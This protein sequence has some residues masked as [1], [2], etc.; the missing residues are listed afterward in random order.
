MQLVDVLES[1]AK[2]VEMEKLNA[3]GIRNKATATEDFTK[4]RKA[5]DQSLI[6]EKQRELEVPYFVFSILP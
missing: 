2:R 1:Q 4:M 6:A 3:V 5:E